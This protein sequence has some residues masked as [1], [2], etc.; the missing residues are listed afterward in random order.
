MQ[1][2]KLHNCNEKQNYVENNS[3]KEEK[4]ARKSYLLFFARKFMNREP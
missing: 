4:E 3:K 2:R 1:I